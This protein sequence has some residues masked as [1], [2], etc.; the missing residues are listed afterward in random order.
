[1]VWNLFYARLPTSRKS[2]RNKETR[3]MIDQS[4]QPFQTRQSLLRDT[5]SKLTDTNLTQEPA[6]TSGRASSISTRS[7]GL[8]WLARS[9]QYLRGDP[10]AVYAVLIGGAHPVHSFATVRNSLGPSEANSKTGYSLFTCWFLMWGRDYLP[11]Q[12]PYKSLF[13]IPAV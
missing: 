6:S 8:L 5:G 13:G 2:L 9:D 7:H 3:T 11:L 12:H 4:A 10:D 1:M